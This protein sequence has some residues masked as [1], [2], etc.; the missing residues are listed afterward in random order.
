VV[1]R[2]RSPPVVCIW[3]QLGGDLVRVWGARERKS[4]FGDRFSS[5]ARC[6]VFVGRS[7]DERKIIGSERK[8]RRLAISE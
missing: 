3:P 1:G 4:I 6:D 5:V 7:G 8:Y 2:H